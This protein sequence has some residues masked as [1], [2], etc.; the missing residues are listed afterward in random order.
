MDKIENTRSGFQDFQVET[1]IFVHN[2]LGVNNHCKHSKTNTL[3]R[4]GHTRTSPAGHG[5]GEGIVLIPWTE[6]PACEV[7]YV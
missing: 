6:D 7:D 1:N 3:A 4:W 5:G 2:R